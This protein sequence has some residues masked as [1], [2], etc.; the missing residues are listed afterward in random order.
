[1]TFPLRL[2]TAAAILFAL[3]NVLGYALTVGHFR[4]FDLAVSS[5][6]NLQTRHIARLAGPDDARHQRDW[7]RRAAIYHRDYSNSGAGVRRSPW[8]FQHLT[9]L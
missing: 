8:G 7:R 9:R 6:L 2:L 4:A 1:M 5:A 3:V